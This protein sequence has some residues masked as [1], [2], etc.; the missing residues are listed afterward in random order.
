MALLLL[1]TRPGVLKTSV[2]AAAATAPP[3]P[4]PSPNCIQ[5]VF[6]YCNDARLQGEYACGKC[7]GTNADALQAA[8]CDDAYITQFCHNKTCVLGSICAA[9]RA[10]AQPGDTFKCAECLGQH[11]AN[12]SALC[13]LAEK[14]AFCSIAVCLERFSPDPIP[15][16]MGCAAGQVRTNPFTLAPWSSYKYY[17]LPPEPSCTP[18]YLAR[19]L[20]LLAPA[21][22]WQDSTSDQ[23]SMQTCRLTTVWLCKRA[24]VLSSLQN[25]W[26]HEQ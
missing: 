21:T 11:E 13:T 26:Q 17:H 9:E 7:A 6:S 1:I 19:S 23:L 15:L 25:G 14:E 18:P 8:G 2:A 5:S 4:S 24:G 16:P 22:K 3:P 20:R 12:I 10:Y